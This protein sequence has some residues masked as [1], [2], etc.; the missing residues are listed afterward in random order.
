[1]DGLGAMRRSSK[2]LVF[3]FY[4]LSHGLAS[5]RERN[6]Q[7]T[8]IGKGLCLSVQ[9]VPPAFLSVRV[10]FYRIGKR[11]DLRT[12]WRREL[13]AP[14]RHA[15]VVTFNPRRSQ[16]FTPFSFSFFF[17]CFV[18]LLERV[19][20]NDFIVMRLCITRLENYL[21]RLRTCVAHVSGSLRKYT[22]MVA[23]NA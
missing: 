7:A 23:L 17:S 21:K 22:C 14:R 10:S 5:S 11:R 6:E 15:S 3:P 16:A 20:L 19:V 4:A 13:P 18:T 8:S 2:K 1:M 12:M 9:T